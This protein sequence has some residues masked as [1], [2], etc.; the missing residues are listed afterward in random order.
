MLTTTIVR[1]VRHAKV[2]PRAKF[3]E[4]MKSL[5][6]RAATSVDARVTEREK[7]AYA[8]KVC[9]RRSLLLLILKIIRTLNTLLLIIILMPT[10]NAPLV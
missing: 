3:V 10:T 9:A 6:I 4:T 2:L 5:D 1:P 7:R 8:A